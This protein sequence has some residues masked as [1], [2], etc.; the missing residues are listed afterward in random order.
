MLDFFTHL[1]FFSNLSSNIE[2]NG[3]QLNQTNYFKLLEY[4]IYQLFQLI[5]EIYFI[6][7]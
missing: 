1:L 6:F 3:G 5:I 7:L 4:E 2:L